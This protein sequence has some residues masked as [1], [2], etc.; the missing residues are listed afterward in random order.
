MESHVPHAHS[1]RKP[2]GIRPDFF[3]YLV[4]GK[5][6]CQRQAQ[7]QGGKTVKFCSPHDERIL[8][9]RRSV[10]E[11][12]IFRSAPAG[13]KPGATSNTDLKTCRYVDPAHAADCGESNRN[14][15]LRTEVANCKILLRDLLKRATGAPR[16]DG[17]GGSARSAMCDRPG[18]NAAHVCPQRRQQN[19][20]MG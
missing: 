2:R 15:G 20:R 10:R 3:L 16:W 8:P 5:R 4:A 14:V 18:R 17:G 11:A 13:L 12:P 7:K 19:M 1:R 6:D 9:E